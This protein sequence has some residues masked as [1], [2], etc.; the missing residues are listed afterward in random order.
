MQPLT[1]KSHNYFQN[2]NNRK[3]THSFAP[4]RFKIQQY[5]RKLELPKTDM[6]KLTNFLKPKKSKL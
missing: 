4:R 5:L 1:L 3:A 6:A 2:E